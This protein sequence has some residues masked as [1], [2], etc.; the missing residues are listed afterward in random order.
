M[1][2]TAML[3]FHLL[4][5]VHSPQWTVSSL[6]AIPAHFLLPFLFR[7]HIFPMMP[8]RNSLN[9]SLGTVMNKKCDT[10]F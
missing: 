6:P 9:N 1:L 3:L 7:I 5:L 2:V 4:F 10:H 8:E